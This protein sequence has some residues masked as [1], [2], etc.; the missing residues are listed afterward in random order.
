M[1]NETDYLWDK[2]GEPDPEIQEL[3]EILGTLRHRPRA[4][5]I[6]ADL[7]IGGRHSFFRGLTPMLAIAAAITLLLFGLALW[8]GL[9][10]LQGGSKPEVVRS[11]PAKEKA[12]APVQP[13]SPNHDQFAHLKPEPTQ[14]PQKKPTRQRVNQSFVAASKKPSRTRP[15]NLTNKSEEFAANQQKALAARDQLFLA[16]RVASEKL[17]FAQR[18]TQNPNPKDIQNQHRIG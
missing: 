6:P 15:N 14:A 9:Q 4:L 7:E 12:P 10:R 1:N 16:L 8:F 11:S 5:E 17:N 2:S 13:A 3:E 18:K